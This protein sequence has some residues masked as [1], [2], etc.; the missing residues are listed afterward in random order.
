MKEM[1]T[2]ECSRLQKHLESQE[3]CLHTLLSYIVTTQHNGNYEALNTDFWLS[4]WLVSAP[5]FGK[6]SLPG[7]LLAYSIL[8]QSLVYY[9]L[10]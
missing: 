7:L 2:A 1:S 4:R 6:K 10:T 3:D 5:A 9:S 8:L